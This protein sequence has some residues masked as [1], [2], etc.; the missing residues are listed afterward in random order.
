MKILS[1]LNFRIVQ[2]YFWIE[3]KCLPISN[4]SNLTL[5]KIHILGLLQILVNF[6][7]LSVNDYFV[8]S[9]TWSSILYEDSFYIIFT[10]KHSFYTPVSR[11]AVLCDWVWWAGGRPH[12]FP[13]NNFSSVYRV[14]TKLGHMIPLWKG[15]NPI[16][17]GV[18]RSKVKV[19]ATINRIFDNRIVSAR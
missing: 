5:I 14:F 11:R 4:S 1:N 8:I 16:Y 15:K 18:I 13:H 6:V 3:I 10:V 17:F 7:N 19:T 2:I 9:I 12:R